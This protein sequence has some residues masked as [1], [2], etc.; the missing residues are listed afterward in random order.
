MAQKAYKAYNKSS[1]LPALRHLPFPPGYIPPPVSIGA[2]GSRH[3]TLTAWARH[4]DHR[5][6]WLRSGFLPQPRRRALCLASCPHSAHIVPAS[7]SLP[8]VCTSGCNGKNCQAT[9]PHPP[10]DP[11]SQVRREGGTLETGGHPRCMSGRRRT[12]GQPSGAGRQIRGAGRHPDADSST[13]C[14]ANCTVP[15]APKALN[16][17]MPW[18]LLKTGPLRNPNPTASHR[19][20]PQLTMPAGLEAPE[21]KPAPNPA[22]P[23][24][25][26]QN[27]HQKTHGVHPECLPSQRPRRPRGTMHTTRK[28]EERDGGNRAGRRGGKEPGTIDKACC[29]AQ[30]YVPCMP[31]AHATRCPNHSPSPHLSCNVPVQRRAG[32]AEVDLASHRARPH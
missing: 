17:A 9:R 31:R 21:R 27:T 12:P 8:A 20:C 23:P 15:R 29:R 26:K 7:C 10:H 14:R 6:M 30:C 22:P 32:S 5:H 24:P 2:G 19:A 3:G 25:K 16:H 11:Q 4:G 13:R 1:P 28:A 18:P